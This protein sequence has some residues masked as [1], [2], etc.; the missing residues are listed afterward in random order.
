MSIY[1]LKK[2]GFKT[3]VTKKIYN[4]QAL[5]SAFASLG[6]HSQEIW[7]IHSSVD[8]CVLKSNYVLFKNL[9]SKLSYK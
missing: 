5:R 1:G 6:C 8:P 7:V 2:L 9:H 4:P 3:Q